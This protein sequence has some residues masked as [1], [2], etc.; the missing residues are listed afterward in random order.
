MIFLSLYFTLLQLLYN[1][2]ALVPHFISQLLCF[3]EGISLGDEKL[4]F[5][6]S[7]QH[8]CDNIFQGAA[9]PSFGLELCLKFLELG[10]M[11]SSDPLLDKFDFLALADRFLGS[12]KFLPNFHPLCFQIDLLI[13]TSLAHIF[14]YLS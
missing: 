11:G 12:G 3:F 10:G 13:R 2:F 6:F 14:I 1:F 7:V 9:L 5:F 4:T 8:P